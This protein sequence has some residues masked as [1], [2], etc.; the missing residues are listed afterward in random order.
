[1]SFARL[2]DIRDIPFVLRR[3]FPGRTA[4]A[5]GLQPPAS[6]T[7]AVVGIVLSMA[8][9]FIMSRWEDR[10]A[11]LAFDRVAENRSMALQHGLDEYLTTLLALRALFDSSD[12]TV[13]RGEFEAFAGTL[14]RYSSAIETLSWVPRVRHEQRASRELAAASEGLSNFEIRTRAADGSLHSAERHDE[15]FPIFYSTAPRESAVYGL[16]LRS[17]LST[18]AELEHAR[19]GD[20]LGFS[21]VAPL[22]GAAGTQDG[23]IFSLPVYQQGLPHATVEDRRRHLVGFVHGSIV[24]AKLIDAVIVATTTTQGLDLFLFDAKGKPNGLP[25]YIHGSRLRTLPSEPRPRAALQAG[26]HWSRDLMAGNAPWVTLVAVATPGGPLATRHDRTWFILFAGLV[27]TAGLAAYLHTVARHNLRLQQANGKISDLAQSAIE[28][29]EAEAAT[30]DASRESAATAR[31]VEMQRLADNFEAAV[32][33]VVEAV[34]TSANK[35]EAAAGT[36]TSAVVTTQ[37]LSATVATASE[38]VSSNVQSVASA[39]G[40][41]AASV[42]EISHQIQESS[43][44]A[45]AAVRQAEATDVRISELSQAASGIGDI[46]K[47]ITAIAQQTKLLALNATIE[48]ARAGEAGKGFSAVAQE[49]KNLASQTANAADEIGSRIADVQTA[50]QD[51]VSAIREIGGTIGRIA[52]IAL[53]IAIAADE[54]GAATRNIASSVQQAAQGTAQVAANISEV[55]RDAA[56]TK[57]ASAEVLASA[58]SLARESGRLRAE[59]NAFLTTIRAA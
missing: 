8:A 30:R 36:L 47:L 17:Q 53:A 46:V 18:L 37:Q 23:F 58:Q 6:L 9:G 56:E 27:L 40:E 34:S 25:L 28:K 24:T 20:Q 26:S 38:E 43:D 7:A 10:Q 55:D 4:R 13:T 50:T 57:A 29:T 48:A 12:D 32:G 33:A 31:R 21:P 1:M 49:V 52:Q 41:M 45:G 16:D 14:L 51:S 2:T 44:I 11:E 42:N 59:V 22:V 19:D 5:W 35:L 39:T 3:R 54:Q 15:Y